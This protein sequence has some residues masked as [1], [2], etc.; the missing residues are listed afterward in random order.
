MQFERAAAFHEKAELSYPQIHIQYIS[1]SH[2]KNAAYWFNCKSLQEP[3][4][5]LGQYPLF[6]KS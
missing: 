1:K 2:Y 6:H 3:K 5:H 4:A